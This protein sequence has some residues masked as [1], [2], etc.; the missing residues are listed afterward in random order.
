MTKKLVVQS[1]K[2]INKD[3][4]KMIK[5]DY[6]DNGI[7]SGSNTVVEKL[8]GEV[9]TPDRSLSYTGTMPRIVSRRILNQVYN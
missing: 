7:G 8:M 9:K 1:G 5:R 3:A 2:V 6:M 4:V